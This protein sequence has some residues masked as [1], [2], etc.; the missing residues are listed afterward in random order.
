MKFRMCLAGAAILVTSLVVSYAQTSST[1]SKKHAA[2]KKATPAGPTVQE[3]ID[4]LRR[5]MQGQIDSLRN[6]LA[7]KDAQLRQA[8]QAAAD[9]QAA[10]AKAEADTQAQQAAFSANTPKA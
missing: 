5:E 10:A 1:A 4:A 2:M 7:D 9:A 6:S 8:Q 3:Q